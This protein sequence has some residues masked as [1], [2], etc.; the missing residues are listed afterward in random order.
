M[1]TRI[2]SFVI[3]SLTCS[4]FLF[5][6]RLGDPSE[7][8]GKAESRRKIKKKNCRDVIKEGGVRESWM[9]H[10]RKGFMGKMKVLNG[11]E[12]RRRRRSIKQER[13]S[14]WKRQS[15]DG[16]SRQCRRLGCEGTKGESEGR[17]KQRVERRSD[18]MEGGKHVRER[19]GVLAFKKKNMAP[20]RAGFPLFT[21]G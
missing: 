16:W 18:L 17:G 21:H 8:V 4:T 13:R 19:R 7:D 14:M 2:L 1:F 12:R 20:V 3:A 6:S 9:E 11:G 5:Q 10:G 15:K